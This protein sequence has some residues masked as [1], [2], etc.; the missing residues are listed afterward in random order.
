MEKDEPQNQY[1]MD[2]YVDK[3]CNISVS[4][5]SV[6]LTNSQ[7]EIFFH[8]KT[9]DREANNIPLVQYIEKNTIVQVMRN[10]KMQIT[11][12]KRIKK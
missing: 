10:M 7:T 12:K 4:G 11:L 3:I 2:I 5:I 8:I 9:S 6:P 1:F